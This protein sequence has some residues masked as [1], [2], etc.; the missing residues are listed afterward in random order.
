MTDN[1]DLIKEYICE[2]DSDFDKNDD[3]FYMIEIRQR[4]KDNPEDKT[5]KSQHT[6]KVYYMNKIA[7]L[8]SLKDE[9]ISMCKMFKARAYISV[10]CKSYEQTSKAM[11]VDLATRIAS[12]EYRKPYAICQSCAAKCVNSKDKR[13]IID[14]DNEDADTLHITIDEYVDFL[15]ECIA[16]C[17]PNGNKIIKIIPSTSGRHIVCKPFDVKCFE[18][19]ISDNFLSADHLIK[20]NSQGTILYSVK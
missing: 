1:F 13:W 20:K 7:D 14:C 8:D 11:M 12:G 4:K 15:I 3:K 17:K 2:C 19:E 9:I 5:I 18:E 6:I 10:N 16:P